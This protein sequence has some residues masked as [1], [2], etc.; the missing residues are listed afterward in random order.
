MRVSRVT[1]MSVRLLVLCGS[2]ALYGCG[3]DSSTNN[4]D[5]T[6][7]GAP[8]NVNYRA[9]MRTFV[10][11]ISARGRA[12]SANFTVV[13][14]NGT[15]LVTDTGTASG[16][17]QTDYLDAISGVGRED[18]LYGFD[19]DD[20]ATPTAE[21]QRLEGLLDVAEAHGVQALVTDYCWTQSKVD[22]SYAR[23]TAAGYTA[24]AADHRELDDIPA[25]PAA[26]NGANAD[27]VTTLRQAR[28]F[29]YVLNPGS[30]DS[31]DALVAAL[32][33]TNYDAFIVDAYFDGDQTLTPAQVA[34]LAQ[35]PGGGKRLVLAYMSI[36]EAENYR[37][38]WQSQWVTSPPAWL[39]AENPD[40]PGNYK[41]RYWDPG[42]KQIILGDGAYLD[43]IIAQGF[44]GVYLDIIDALEYFES[45]P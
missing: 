21:T 42:W 32:A 26:L 44:D 2:A 34:A 39:A 6:N 24:F 5:D 36:G 22:D 7:N 35:K 25:Y 4:G 29:L 30:Y 28:N 31:A 37:P 40:W 43:G 8:S 13:P 41:V 15:E 10:E 9:E 14:Q 1:C 12:A 33:A 16:L 19:A 3:G 11:Q 17:A 38:Y 20:V 45:T 18:L 23:N 27:A